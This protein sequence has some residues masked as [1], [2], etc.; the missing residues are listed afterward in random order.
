MS[1]YSLLIKK[2]LWTVKNH[3]KEIK[4][5]PKRLIPY[6]LGLLW[7]G[8]LV[9]STVIRINHGP[10]E[11]QASIGPQVIGAVF[12]VLMT[13]LL[14]YNIYRGTVESATF[15]SMGDVHFLFP[16]P[17]P[18]KRILLYNM[19]KQTLQQFFLYGIVIFALTP[20]ILQGTRINLHYVHLFYLGYITPI[21]MM[22]SLNFLIFVIGS[23]YKLQSE[24]QKGILG[25]AAT[26][27]LY[28]AI[29]VIQTGGTA[30]G[31]LQGLNAPFINYLPIIGWGKSAFMA[32]LS[33]Y[34][35]FGTV[36]VI[37]QLALLGL[38]ILL[39]YRT[40][41]DYYEDVLGA[42]EK[43][44]LRKRQK[45]GLEKREMFSFYRKKQVTVRE[46]GTGPQALV[47]KA[48][49]ESSRTD[50]HRY[51]GFL[52]I[53]ALAIGLMVGFMAGK[54][55]AGVIPLYVANGIAAYMIFIFSA[56]Q[57]RFTEWGKPYIYLMPGSP[58][59]KII[60]VNLHDIIRM[61][62]NALVL[63]IALSVWIKAELITMA[64]M[65]LFV[66]S[67]YI[68]N[69]LSGFITRALF[70]DAIDQKALFPLFMMLQIILLLLPGLAAGG[71]M[72][73]IFRTPL[74]FFQGIVLLNA[75]III[76][77]LALSSKIYN[78]LEWR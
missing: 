73:F 28:T 46:A 21:L 71:I 36:A 19:I 40:A 22:A 74:A 62:I 65:V 72:A 54:F 63:N 1:D 64:T 76:I 69:L 49:V 39:S 70:P 59:R 53:A 15:F 67:F 4:N 18:P 31:L 60:A 61:T 27:L 48:R 33:G 25:L 32:P 55:P 58:F 13:V 17:V 50:L 66:I 77:L 5:S 3:I 47:W 43:R 8:S 24:L 57:N 29:I 78:Y 42:T 51:F 37:M 56:W 45:K 12:T 52:T 38:L 16:A 34:S 41:D 44:T 6:L 30:A 10:T 23:K 20:T 2:D 9:F 14:L 7:I 35:P 11:M 75:V 68:F 26:A